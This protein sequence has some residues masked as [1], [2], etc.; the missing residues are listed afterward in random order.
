[1]FPDIQCVPVRILVKNYHIIIYDI[2]TF[3]SCFPGLWIWIWFLH[4]N[5]MTWI[6]D[7]KKCETKTKRNL[8]FGL[9]NR[10]A[11]VIESNDTPS[12]S[13]SLIFLSFFLFLFLFHLLSNVVFI[14]MRSAHKHYVTICNDGKK[15]LYREINDTCIRW[16]IRCSM[17]RI[18]NG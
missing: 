4:G 14:W 12:P 7:R 16:V 11:C 2:H 13:P 3:I 10:F 8:S 6:F 18:Q 17:Y 15:L 5:I 9:N 1:M